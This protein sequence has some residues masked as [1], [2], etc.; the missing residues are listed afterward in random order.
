MDLNGFYT[1]KDSR[2]ED[3]KTYKELA[4]YYEGQI[5]KCDSYIEKLDD[6]NPNKPAWIELKKVCE[7]ELAHCRDKLR[8]SLS[9]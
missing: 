1:P 4:S 7:Q 6:S 2:W 3:V 5:Q 9:V 8:E